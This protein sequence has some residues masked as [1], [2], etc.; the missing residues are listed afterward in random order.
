MIYLPNSMRC[1]SKPKSCYIECKILSSKPFFIP[2]ICNL[3]RL[4]FMNH[5]LS[6]ICFFCFRGSRA[7]AI[8]I[9]V[10]NIAVSIQIV[11]R[12][13]EIKLL[14]YMILIVLQAFVMTGYALLFFPGRWISHKNIKEQEKIKVKD[15]FGSA[16][17]HDENTPV[18][19]SI[20]SSS[21]EKRSDSS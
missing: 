8:L 20:S 17:Q 16:L 9:C 2:N 13:D 12:T 15:K 21:I 1:A 18:V 14:C 6:I 5:F 4:N 11:I 3:Y 19:E 10:I 7:L